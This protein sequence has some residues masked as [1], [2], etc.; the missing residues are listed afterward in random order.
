MAKLS[1]DV[2]RHVH[3]IPTEQLNSNSYRELAMTVLSRSPSF[4]SISQGFIRETESLLAQQHSLL[5]QCQRMQYNILLLD[6]LCGCGDVQVCPHPITVALVSTT[7]YPRCVNTNFS[8][9]PQFNR[10]V[11]QDPAVPCSEEGGRHQLHEDSTFAFL[12]LQP[13]IIWRTTCEP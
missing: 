8:G 10:E 9:S 3:F 6:A 12:L 1:R 5:V 13:S 11:C 2:W 4:D 7:C